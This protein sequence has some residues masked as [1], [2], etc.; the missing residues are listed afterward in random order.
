MEC[1]TL[2]GNQRH[3]EMFVTE[4]EKDEVSGED[5][6]PSGRVLQHIH[7]MLPRLFIQGMHVYRSDCFHLFC[8]WNVLH[9]LGMGFVCCTAVYH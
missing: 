9:W 3:S 4:L 1:L 8:D 2:L 7:W 6:G 5:L